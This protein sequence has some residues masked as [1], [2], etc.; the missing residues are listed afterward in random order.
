MPINLQ[1]YSNITV[2]SYFLDETNSLGEKNDFA[3]CTYI[4]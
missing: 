4:D 2:I 3:L 1:K